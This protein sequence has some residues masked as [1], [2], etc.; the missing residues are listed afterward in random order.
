MNTARPPQP[1]PSLASGMLLRLANGLQYVLV[2]S[3]IVVVG[4]STMPVAR[5]AARPSAAPVLPGTME[6]V[7][8]NDAGSSQYCVACHRQVAPA[9]GTIDVQ[10]GHSQNVKLSSAQLRAV[11]EM[12]TV[13]GPGDTLI[14][15]SCHKLGTLGDFMLADTLEGSKLCQRCHSGHYAQNT[16]HD[17]RLSAPGEK[18]RFGIAVADGG[19]C[20]ACHMAHA[21]AREIVSTPLDPDGYCITCHR[22]F[23]VAE[24]R[25][26]TGFTQQHPETHCL[27]CHDAHDSTHGSF[28]CASPAEL[29]VTCHADYADATRGMHPLGAM[30]A[31]VPDELR[32][33]G[34]DAGADGHTISCVTC[35]S[36]HEP[37]GASLLVMDT[38][39][40]DLCL[41]CHRDALVDRAGHGSLPRHGQMPT[42][43]AEQVAVVRSFGGSVGTKG[44]LLCVSCHRVHGSHSSREL[45]AFEPRFADSCIGCHP[46]QATVVGSSHDLRTNFPN[47]KNDL[48]MSASDGGACSSCH[49]AHGP[50][51]A[52]IVTAA[53]MT[54]DCV[55]CHREG[56]VAQARAYGGMPHPETNCVRCHDPHSRETPAFLVRNESTL[57]SECHA[58]QARLAGGPHDRLTTPDS[59]RWAAAASSGTSAAAPRG[60]ACLPCHVP[61]GGERADLFRL[62]TGGDHGNHDDVCLGCHADAAWRADSAIAAIH[63]HEIR[64]D[65]QLVDVALVPKDSA[66]NLRIGCRTCHDPHSGSEP[67]HLARV[68]GGETT[69][70]LCLRCHEQKRFIEQTGH[71]SDRL[72]RAGFSVDSCKPCHAMHARPDAAWGRMLS[73]RFMASGAPVVTAE[74]DG[75]APCMTCH[76]ENGPAPVREIASH[77]QKEMFNVTPPD[78]PGYLPLFNA[79]GHEDPQG[80]VTCRTCH[81]SHGRIDLLQQSAANAELSPAERRA[82]RMQLRP[83]EPPN[84]CTTCHGEEARAKFLFFHKVENRGVAPGG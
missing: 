32:E 23:G 39:N 9:I 71:A 15:M 11:A 4:L 63:P 59:P 25:A 12:G 18:N 24:K 35:H 76:H 74:N 67:A 68:T 33:R 19:P 38:S 29:C 41:S 48:G 51:R 70:S 6:Q 75:P 47:E 17:L 45:L 55:N 78:A 3:A 66:G 52:R 69:A 61:H 62:G 1:H 65:E 44:E 2:V 60:G 28:L 84:V 40:N 10:R 79:V 14:C 82:M 53:D 30:N 83:F 27:K 5:N 49:G 37:G 54:G 13:A 80:Q 16:P 20:S 50:G 57:C 8:W 73:T 64:S 56:G 72:A 46:K 7:N 77:P 34:A 31:G 58:D 26:R 43:T 22:E 21:H 81:V 36:I 42:L